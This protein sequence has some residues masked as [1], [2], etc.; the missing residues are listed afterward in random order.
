MSNIMYMDFDPK[1]IARSL[2]E[3]C[4]QFENET[5]KQIFS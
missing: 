5:H 1:R 4:K 2:Q 3:N